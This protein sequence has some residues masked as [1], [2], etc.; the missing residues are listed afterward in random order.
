ME[1]MEEENAA[2]QRGMLR[3]GPGDRS[4]IADDLDEFG[5]P[6]ER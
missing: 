1:V 4:G 6:E 3:K 2:N 5:E